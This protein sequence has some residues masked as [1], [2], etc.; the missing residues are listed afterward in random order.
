MTSTPTVPRASRLILDAVR[1]ADLM[2]PNPMSLCAE[3][4]VP[5]AITWL[6]EKGFSAAP[7]IDESGRTV[8]V[9]SRAD[10]LVHERDRLRSSLPP[11]T[12]TTTV[13]DIMTPVVFSVTP[14]M[15][16]ALIIEQ[17]LSLNVHQLYVVDEHDALIG[18]ISARDV[19]RH[20]HNNH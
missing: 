2:T 20:L 14:R 4:T 12:D 15:P 11:V 3:A 9:V 5:E 8:G 17:M 1:A 18:V 16:V 6:T 7:V 19:L 10:I 13:R